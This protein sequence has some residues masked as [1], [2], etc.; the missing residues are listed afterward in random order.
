MTLKERP[1]APPKPPGQNP[2]M[3]PFPMGPFPPM[4]TDL[5]KAMMP[6]G[7]MFP[8]VIPP[9]GPGMN[10]SGPMPMFPSIIPPTAFLPDFTNWKI[11]IPGEVEG[12]ENPVTENAP[13]PKPKGPAKAPKPAQKLVPT[14]PGKKNRK[15]V[16]G[17]GRRPPN[18]RKKTKTGKVIDTTDDK[19]PENE[20]KA[21]PKTG[22]GIGNFFISSL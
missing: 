14:K 3:P 15:P 6:P 11:T 5:S 20:V 10:G 12:G 9:F 19:V 18:K 16:R 17:G 2:M 13:A 22:N 7:P 8:P 21:S 1:P 4:D